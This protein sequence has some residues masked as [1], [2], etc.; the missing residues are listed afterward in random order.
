MIETKLR[1]WGNS[2]GVL[3]PKGELERDNLKENDSIIVIVKR[4]ISPA[5]ELF[6]SLMIKEPTDKIMREIDE[7]FKSRFD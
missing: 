2:F 4:K 3:I 7:K 1:R 5:K 6:G